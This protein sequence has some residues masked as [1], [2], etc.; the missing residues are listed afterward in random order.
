[1][2]RAWEPIRHA[3]APAPFVLPIEAV[4][5]WLTCAAR[6]EELIYACAARLSGHDAGALRVRALAEACQVQAYQRAAAP[7]LFDY[8]ARRTALPLSPK[9]VPAARALTSGVSDL[10]EKMASLM[11]EL[12]L[13]AR[14]GRPCSSNHVLA[15]RTGLRDRYQAKYLLAKA[16][17]RG[18]I[19]VVGVAQPPGRV[20]TILASGRQTG[21]QPCA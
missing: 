6:G 18:L 8:V 4:N 5:Q 14:S 16:Q 1:M 9:A 10:D 11:A 12:K 19:T 7:G 13:L 3:M 15:E 20:V 2:T 21:V 17:A